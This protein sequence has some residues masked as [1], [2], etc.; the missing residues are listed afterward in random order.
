MRCAGWKG[1]LILA[2]A[3]AM[4]ALMPFWASAYYLELASTALIAAMFA[5]SLQILVGGVGLVAQLVGT[6]SGMVFALA[7]GLLVYGGLKKTM[8]IRLE[9]EKEQRGADLSIH[10]I[11]AYP[12]DDASKS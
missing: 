1:N 4:V 9:P 2:V 3:A 7:A 8:G 10:R 6:L 11:T 12:E 5:L